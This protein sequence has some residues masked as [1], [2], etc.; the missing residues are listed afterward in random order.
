MFDNGRG[1]TVKGTRRGGGGDWGLFRFLA[2][3]RLVTISC[4]HGTHETRFVY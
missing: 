2:G 1:M 3:I 4:L